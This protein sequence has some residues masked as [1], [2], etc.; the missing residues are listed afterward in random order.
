[1]PATTPQARRPA[2]P[3]TTIPDGN[4]VR[5]VGRISATPEVHALDGGG[6]L[7][8]LRVVVRRPDGRRVDSL[9]VV[10]GPAG[11]GRREPGR[12][13]AAVVTRAAGLAVDD[14][15]TVEGWLQRHFWD[16][17]GRRLSRLQVVATDVRRAR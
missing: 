7:V 9:P 3:T 5:L 8:V 13:R 10:V 4:E 12:A 15:V 14:R 6:T 11:G 1:M 17:A 16:A 2:A